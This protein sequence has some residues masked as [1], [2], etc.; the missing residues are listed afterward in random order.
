MPVT[1]ERRAPRDAA[2][3]PARHS[4]GRGGREAVVVELEDVVGG[5]DHSPLAADG[6][7]A[8]A[9]EAFDRAV[10][11][12]LAEHGLDRDLALAVELA[13][14]GGR[15]DAAHGVVEAARPAGPGALAQPAVGWD[16]HRD[17]VAGD[18]FDLALMP[19]AGVGQDDLGIA[20][21]D[22]AQLAL[23]GPDHR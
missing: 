1:G 2:G 16:E 17:A 5:G 9:L 13:A 8:A 10:E 23:G 3:C 20:Q 11:L 12:D 7:S 19:V 6:G 14:L 18:L 4:S 22:R 15:E 21:L